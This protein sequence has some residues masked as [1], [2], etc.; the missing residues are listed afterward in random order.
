MLIYVL[1]LLAGLFVYLKFVK[2]ED[3]VKKPERQEDG[4]E[5]EVVRERQNVRQRAQEDEVEEEDE[6]PNRLQ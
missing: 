6:Q 3:E 1:L 5:P 4:P 2:K